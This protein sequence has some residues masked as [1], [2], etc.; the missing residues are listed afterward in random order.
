MIESA[1]A[2]AEDVDAQVTV[3][4]NGGQMKNVQVDAENYDVVQLLVFDDVSLGRD[5]TVEL[6]V[7]G[8]GSLMYQISGSFYL[9]W[10]DLAKYPELIPAEELISIDVAYDR[11]ELSVNDTVNVA[12][13][14]A[15][16]RPGARSESAII[17]LGLPPGFT[18][19]AEDLAALVA[20][21]NDVPQDYQ[22]A[23]IQRYELTGRQIIIYLTN[24]SEGKQ[25]QFSF[26][27]RAKYPKKPFYVVVEDICASGGYYVAAAADKIFVN[28]A[29]IIGSIGVLMDGFGLTG[30]CLLYTSP[31]PRDR[32]RSR[33]PS[34]A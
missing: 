30:T 26:R 25:L 29:S 12:V 31:S 2:G 24:L 8:K 11:S 6:S 21:Y 18:V 34:S 32:T 1:R 10:D 20:Y 15:L 28:K 5:N 33:M 4:L 27:L 23:Q 19:E 7:T 14:I 13:Q 17:D 16:N 9:P 3:S 22:F